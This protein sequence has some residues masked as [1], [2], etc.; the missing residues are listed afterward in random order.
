MLIAMLHGLVVLVLVLMLLRLRAKMLPILVALLIAVDMVSVA[1]P[2]VKT[3]SSEVTYQIDQYITSIGIVTNYKRP[4][5]KQV[6]VKLVAMGFVL[7]YALW[8]YEYS[9]N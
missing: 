2:Y 3:L 9:S 5:M 4:Y 7:C 8:M 1:K 6:L